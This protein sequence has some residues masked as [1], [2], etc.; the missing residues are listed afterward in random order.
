LKSSIKFDVP[1]L[2]IGW[3]GKLDKMSRSTQSTSVTGFTDDDLG[4]NEITFPPQREAATSIYEQQQQLL[5]SINDI[6][7]NLL[8]L[9]KPY[10]DCMAANTTVNGRTC[11]G[12]NDTHQGKKPK[13]AQSTLGM[14]TFYRTFFVILYGLLT[15]F[16]QKN[17]HIG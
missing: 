11:K 10:L 12:K 13:W 15:R 1:E 8:N 9:N 5:A 17:G 16:Y 4:I 2:F 14:L 6:Q 7:R 3:Q